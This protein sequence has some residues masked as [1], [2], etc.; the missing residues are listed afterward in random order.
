MGKTPHLAKFKYQVHC[1]ME[2]TNSF[3]PTGCFSPNEKRQGSSSFK[4]NLLR[5]TNRISS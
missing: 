1:H 4:N 5:S 3:T 2:E